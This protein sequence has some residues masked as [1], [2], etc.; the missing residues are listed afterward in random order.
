VATI[1]D[2]TFFHAGVP[3]LIDAVVQRVKF[4]LVILDNRTTGMTGNQPTPA[5]GFGASGEP[6]DAVEIESVVR[7]C[8]VK[9]CR[10]GD[11]YRLQ[12]FIALMKEAVARGREK[13]PAVVIARHPCLLDRARRGE[14]AEVLSV[15]ISE[16]CDGCGYCVKNFECPALVH[17]T[18]DK[19][20]KRTTIDPM[21]CAGCGVCLHVCPKGS[22]Q[23]KSQ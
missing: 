9:Y 6:L 10:T 2:S 12:D 23:I 17:H 22:F 14:R 5:S 4:T 11:P 20:H 19:D 8:G 18:Q 15:E 21:V 16:R 1:G 13:G 3:A 7:G